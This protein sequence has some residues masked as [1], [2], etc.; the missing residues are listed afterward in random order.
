MA[1][2]AKIWKGACK[3]LILCIQEYVSNFS[4]T[5]GSKAVKKKQIYISRSKFNL[6]TSSTQLIPGAA[7]AI[8]EITTC[9][10]P[11]AAAS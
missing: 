3:N 4:I 10:I 11:L 9:V 7:I 2:Q 1:P 6:D 8:L 5:R